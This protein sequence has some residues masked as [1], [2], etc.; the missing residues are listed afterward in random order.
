L[1]SDGLCAAILAGAGL[2]SRAAASAGSLHD[3]PASVLHPHHRIRDAVRFPLV[4]VTRLI[5]RQLGL[6]HSIAQ[7]SLDGLIAQ[8]RLPLRQRAV[9]LNGGLAGARGYRIWNLSRLPIASLGGS[10]HS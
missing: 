5:Y 8:R 3:V 4:R 1:H 2:S 9:S 7:P 10:Q 6:K